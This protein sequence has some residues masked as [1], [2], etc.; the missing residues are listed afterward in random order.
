MAHIFMFLHQYF[1]LNDFARLWNS[2]APEI[3]SQIGVTEKVQT[4]N[5]RFFESPPLSPKL[6]IFWV[7]PNNQ[8]LI[9]SSKLG[10]DHVE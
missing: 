8:R 1:R 10:S 2:A 3:K 5:A 9:S 4:V 6:G 7:I